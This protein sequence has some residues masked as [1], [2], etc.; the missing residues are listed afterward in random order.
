MARLTKLV[1]GNKL[2]VSICRD[3]EDLIGHYVVNCNLVKSIV[4]AKC[5]HV[6]A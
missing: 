4:I 1:H 2:D 5:W 6:A 3:V